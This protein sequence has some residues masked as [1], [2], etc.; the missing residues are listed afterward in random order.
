MMLSCFLISI[1]LIIF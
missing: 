1:Q